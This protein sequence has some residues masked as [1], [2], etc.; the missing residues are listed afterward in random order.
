MAAHEINRPDSGK[1]SAAVRRVENQ[2][3]EFP[4]Y[5]YTPGVTPHPISNPAG[6]SYG[7][8]PKTSARFDPVNFADCDSY[9]TGLELFQNG[10]FWEAHEEWEAAWNSVGRKGMAADFLKGLIKLAA[11]GVKARE[12]SFDGVTRHMRRALELFRTVK[13]PGNRIAGLDLNRVVS[14]VEQARA[15]EKPRLPQPDGQ[16]VM[17]WPGLVEFDGRL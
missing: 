1:R 7:H 14:C 8:R 3:T 4:P 5:T 16:P 9:V 15:L 12:G 13:L 10:F 6:H 11:A 17:F 2:P